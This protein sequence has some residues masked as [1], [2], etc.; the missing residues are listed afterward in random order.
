LSNEMKFRV[1]GEEYS[2]A[3]GKECVVLTDDDFFRGHDKAY[4]RLR[5]LAYI[6]F[7]NQYFFG[8][9][10]WRIR[11]QN[12]RFDSSTRSQDPGEYPFLRIGFPGFRA[13]RQHKR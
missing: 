10:V 11:L 2:Q 8:M 7:S 12:Q 5:Q 6:K 9:I 4:L 13:Q 1:E 3:I